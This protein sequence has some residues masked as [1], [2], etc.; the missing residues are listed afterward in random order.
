MITKIILF[1]ILIAIIIFIEI[2]TILISI[3]SGQKSVRE[4]LNK[5]SNDFDKLKNLC[6]TARYADYQ[7]EKSL[8]KSAIKWLDN[9]IACCI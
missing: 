4:N 5:I 6:L 2:Y 7:I 8:T 3:P 9:I 1:L